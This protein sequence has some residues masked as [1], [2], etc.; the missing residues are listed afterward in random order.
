MC[1]INIMANNSIKEL[2]EW[3]EEKRIDKQYVR[4]F[5]N[6]M[7]NFYGI[8]TNKSDLDKISSNYLKCN[9]YNDIINKKG[10]EFCFIP[11]KQRI[12]RREI[13]YKKFCFIYEDTVIENNTKNAIFSIKYEHTHYCYIPIEN[14][15]KDIIQNYNVYN[16]SRT[17]NR[18]AFNAALYSPAPA[19]DVPAKPS[20][21]NPSRGHATTVLSSI[22][23][24][25]G[26]KSKKSKK[27]RKSRKSKKSRK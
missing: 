1:I 24:Y 15:D 2:N 5:I 9:S 4:T 19:S 18:A 17:M 6:H 22:S 11:K 14:I 8:D 27:S 3:I 13:L 16:M 12:V 10:I 7:L 21:L 20:R 23:S 26:G 25:L